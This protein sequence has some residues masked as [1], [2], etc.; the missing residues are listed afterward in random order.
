MRPSPFSIIIVFAA[1]MLIGLAFVPRLGIQLHPSDELPAMRISFSWTGAPAIH[2]E[3]EVTSKI[4][5]SLSTMRGLKEISSVSQFGRG[6]VDISLKKGSNTDLARFEV[7]AHIRRLYPG[8][9]EGVSYPSISA[10]RASGR[11]NPLLTYTIVAPAATHDI[12]RHIERQVLPILA[13]IPGIDNVNLFGARPFEYQVVYQPE[14][15][16]LWGIAPEALSLALQQY[17]GESF[18]GMAPIENETTAFRI[19]MPAML[20][21]NRHDPPQWESIPVGNH[22]GRVI[23]LTELASVRLVEE[24][25]LNYYRINGQTT[26]LMAITAARGQNQI[27]LSNMVR[28]TIDQLQEQLPAGWQMILTYDDTEFIRKDLRRV[29]FRMLFSFS[30]LMLFVLLVA[31]NFKYLFIILA[32]VVANLL[33]AVSW[34][35]LLGIEIH[36]YSLAGI[37]VSF[38]II[39]DNS[40][41]MIEHMRN[42]RNK[43]VFLAILAATL[44]T[45]GSLSVI[46]LLE[47]QQQV[48]LKDFAGV[49]LVNLFLSL[50]VAWFFIPALFAKSGMARKAESFFKASTRRKVRLSRAYLKFMLLAR[51]YRWL[52]FVLLVL[53]FGLPVHMLPSR[54]DGEGVGA[55]VYNKTIGSPFYQQR[56]K[57]TAEKVLGGSFRLFSQFVY[58]RSFFSDPERTTIFI[59]GQMPDGAT[60]QQINEAMV[61]MEDFLLGFPQIEQFQTR[62]FSHD[63]AYISVQFKPEFDRG[64]FPHVLQNRVIQKALSIGGAEWRVWGVGQGFS[65]VLGSGGGSGNIVLEGYN[66]EQLYRYAEIL[67]EKARQNPRV[68]KPAI[69]GAEPWRSPNR[70]EFFMEFDE[71]L[72]AMHGLNRHSVFSNLQQMVMKRP[73]Q[74]VLVDDQPVP[75]SLVPEEYLEYSVW[76]LA[77]KPLHIHGNYFKPGSLVQL[78]KKAIGNDIYKYNQQYRLMFDFTFLGPPTL[79]ERLNKQLLE[80]INQIMPL[81]YQASARQWS[82][83]TEKKS[84]YLLI[85]LVIVIIFFICAILLESLLQPLAIIGLIPISFSGLFL[86]FYLFNLN[87]DQGG[88]AAFILLS[89]LAV[90]A[91]LYILNDFN[92]YRKSHQGRNLPALYLKAFQYKI[93]PVLLTVFSTIIGLIPFLIGKKEAFWFAFAAGTI[94]GLVFSL[95]AILLF[96]PVFLKFKA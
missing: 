83:Q 16:R 13:Q 47:A 38:G 50:V 40:I 17:F 41:V 6:Y 73:A 46:F 75:I 43:R 19:S 36:L 59:R 27:R 57:R 69:Y 74:N 56:I 29:G 10:S 45:M 44:T 78:E 39:I 52:V 79:Q 1:L 48:Q 64:A 89:G 85:L 49:V 77:N 5:S 31:R 4:E 51:R 71:Q 76:D 22:N 72:L 92:N 80:E 68:S 26:L 88:W 63:N 35:Y 87:F 61:Q 3:R 65:N 14:K 95:M 62:V 86:T 15:M 8:F 53:G 11:N 34:Y 18:M 33:L 2:V 91:G 25:P 12:A 32:T 21:A 66:Y 81:G 58:E 94:G 54:L 93:F 28:Q 37:T 9:P 24:P 20:R 55:A 30:V 90:N 7:S 84:Q 23:F 42:H 67:M 70:M 82:W 60:L 96:F